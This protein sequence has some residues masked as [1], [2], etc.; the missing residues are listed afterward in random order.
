MMWSRNNRRAPLMREQFLQPA[1]MEK[2][3]NRE[4]SNREDLPICLLGVR[5]D[6]A[7]KNNRRGP[8]FGKQFP[9]P[10][11]NRKGKQKDMTRREIYA[12][13]ESY[14]L[15]ILIEKRKLLNDETVGR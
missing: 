2:K 5:S 9:Q 8:L 11:F 12:N 13:F 15:R 1:T 3:K 6:N 14:L 7:V 4:G 10:V